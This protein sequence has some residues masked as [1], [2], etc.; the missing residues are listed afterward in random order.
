MCNYTYMYTYRNMYKHIITH[1]KNMN[2][3]KKNLVIQ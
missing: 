2:K 1:M 3:Y